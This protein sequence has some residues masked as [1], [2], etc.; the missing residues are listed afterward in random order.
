MF[1]KLIDL[2][3][4][5]LIFLNGL[6]SETYDDF[7]LVIT[8][9][10]YWSPLFLLIFYLLQKKLGWKKFGYYILFTAVLILISDQTA[11]LFKNSFQRLRP[12]NLEELKGIIRVVKSSSSFSFYSGHATNSMAST[13]FA[14]MILKQ[15]YNHSYLLFLF[16]LIF[17]FSRIY[18]GLHFPSDILTGYLFG[19]TFG[20]IC[21]KL[22]QKYILKTT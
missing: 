7:W 19:A 12:C 18:L 21:Y 9:Q 3:H 13:V 4:K 16:P 1:D 15:Y 2:D 8:K 6:G 10:I 14:F 11:N 22:Y 20:F 5:I 17:A